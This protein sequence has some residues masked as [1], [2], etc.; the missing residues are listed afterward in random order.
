MA[1][2]TLPLIAIQITNDDSADAV[3]QE[4][5]IE[6][7]QQPERSAADFQVSHPLRTVNRKQGTHG[8]QFDNELTSD[9]EIDATPTVE[10]YALVQDGHFTLPFELD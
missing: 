10:R 1:P 3:P 5:H 6:I 2:W 8:L 7:D 9:E 4:R